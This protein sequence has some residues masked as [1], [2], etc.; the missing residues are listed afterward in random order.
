MA[1]EMGLTEVSATSVALI[2]QIVQE[3]LKQRAIILPTVTDRTGEVVKGGK[4]VGFPRRTEFAAANKAENTDLT[5][6][7]ITFSVDTL[8]LNI[9]K[10]ILATLEDIARIQA[11]PN[12]DAEIIQE[13]ANEI[14]LQVDKDLIVQLKLVSTAAPDHLLDYSNS[15]TDTLLQT[16]ILE[17]RKLL[18]TAKVPLTDRFMVIPPDQEKAVLLISDFVRA[19]TYGTPAGL[20]EAEL[21]R[22]YGF[23]V[24]MHT[25]LAAADSLFYH[26]S[27]VG[28]ASQ[29][30]AKF[31]RD[32]NV[33]ALSDEFALSMLYGTKVLDSGKRGVYFNGSG[34]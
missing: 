1:G 26:K 6:Q 25:E 5:N 33:P 28:Y 2:S 14:A 27:H 17:A 16:D 19:D 10:G 23:T 4:S 21:G 24:M 3:T 22:I 15:P 34:A 29:I 18:N 7:V 9:H 8:D 32:R 11:T 20:R 30:A 12:V 31:D 13:M